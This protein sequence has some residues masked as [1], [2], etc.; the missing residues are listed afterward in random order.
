MDEPK[1]VGRRSFLGQAGAAVVG[2]GALGAATRSTALSY[3]RI[4]GANDRIALGHIGVGN[5]GRGLDEDRRPP[6]RSAERRGDGRLRSLEDEPQEGGHRGDGQLRPCAALV[7]VHGG[8]ARAEGRRRGARLDRRLPARAAPQAGRRGGQGLLLRE[9]DGERPRGRE[10]RPRRRHESQPGRADR[11]PAPQRAVP[12]RRAEAD[13]AARSATSARSRSSGTTTARAG[14]AGR[15]SGSFASRT[16][17]GG[18]GCSPSRTGRST[19]GSTS[20]SASTA[21]SRA[22]SPTSG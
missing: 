12:D 9:A 6:Q 22:A 15:R 14:A 19:R 16:P 13:P 3:G 8:A 2:A 21:T 7:Q 10:G 5:R 11:H 18:G 17:T 1:P 4:L 20:S